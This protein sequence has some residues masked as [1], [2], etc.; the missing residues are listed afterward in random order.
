MSDEELVPY[1]LSA[2]APV[3]MVIQPGW[4]E[5]FTALTPRRPTNREWA[6]CKA[7]SR[8]FRAKRRE[9]ER[10]ALREWVDEVRQRLGLVTVDEDG[11]LVFPTYEA[12]LA[13]VRAEEE[14]F[15]AEVRRRAEAVADLLSEALPDDL[16]FEWT[17]GP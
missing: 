13:Y 4:E 17:D 3:K 11:E 8:G 1:D 16:R 9:L 6:E 15:A 12:A 5:R 2:P 14:A 7:W 10:A